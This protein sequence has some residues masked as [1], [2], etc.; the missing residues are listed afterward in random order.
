MQSDRTPTRS[1]HLTINADRL[2][3]LSRAHGISTDAEL[4][5]VIGVNPATLYRVRE[6]KTVASN[7]FLAKVADAFPNASLDHLFELVKDAA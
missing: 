3:T 7:E 1:L 2:N 6:G 5:R 4:A